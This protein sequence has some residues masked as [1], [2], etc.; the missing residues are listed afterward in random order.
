MAKII[1]R[2]WTSTGPMGKKV[3]HTSF[4]YTLTINGTRE[5][6]FSSDWVSEAD[7]LKALS[8]RQE[9]LKAGRFDKP[10]DVTFGGERGADGIEL[11]ETLAEVFGRAGRAALGKTQPLGGIGKA[12]GEAE[13]ST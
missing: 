2:E 4:G 11:L 10:V 7:A 12:H 8:E 1:R 13:R 9:H 3:K 6:K 5:R